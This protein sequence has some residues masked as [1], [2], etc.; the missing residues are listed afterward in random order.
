[1]DRGL[2]VGGDVLDINSRLRNVEAV[3]GLD[4][5]AWIQ[6]DPSAR[7]SAAT[8]GR[9]CCLGLGLWWW[10]L[11]EDRHKERRAHRH[12]HHHRWSTHEAIPTHMGHG[13]DLRVLFFALGS[14]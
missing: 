7:Q 1:M 13:L 10:R 4:I 9:H 8:D 14:G 3:K 5:L 12:Q 2:W 11:R 6:V